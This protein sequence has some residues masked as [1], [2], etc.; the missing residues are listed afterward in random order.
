MNQ[1]DQRIEAATKMIL[2]M[3]YVAP[4]IQVRHA[5]MKAIAILNMGANLPC[6]Y[7]DKNPA[8]DV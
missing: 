2:D 5:R 3:A 7:T 8:R 1:Q 4:E 6:H